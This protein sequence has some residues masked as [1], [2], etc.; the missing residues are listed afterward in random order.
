MLIWQISNL[1][2]LVTVASKVRYCHEFSVTGDNH[3]STVRLLHGFSAAHG[4]QS[5]IGLEG[6][7]GMIRRLYLILWSETDD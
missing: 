2:S 7:E 5:H 3:T 1:D 4:I 6:V